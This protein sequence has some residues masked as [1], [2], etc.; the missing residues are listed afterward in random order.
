LQV[1]VERLTTSDRREG[2]MA[3]TTIHTQ[4]Q[5]RLER[6]EELRTELRARRLAELDQLL[7]RARRLSERGEK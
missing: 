5:D 7:K 6:L 2:A 3:T 4:A 1:L